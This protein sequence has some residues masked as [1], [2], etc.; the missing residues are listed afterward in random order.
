MIAIL[1]IPLVVLL[2]IIQTTVV[3]RLNISYGMMDIVLVSLIAVGIHPRSKHII[4][5]FLLAG[6]LLAIISPIRLMYPLVPYALT[7]FLVE[8]LRKRIWRIP[9]ILMAILTFLGSLIS[10]F[11]AYLTIYFTQT[12]LPLMDSI[13]QVSLPSI[14]LN[15]LI[16]LP[17]YLVIKDW[18]DTLSPQ[19]VE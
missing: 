1:G 10:Q 13:L 7:G 16:G 9:L 15:I 3:S 11:T 4:Y 5:W 6:F 8:Y 12:A 18:G 19:E 14:T 17:I 2:V